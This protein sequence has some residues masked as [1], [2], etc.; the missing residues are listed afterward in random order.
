MKD[1]IK[2]NIILTAK[3]NARNVK[4]ISK[5]DFYNNK[6]SNENMYIMIKKDNSIETSLCTSSRKDIFMDIFEKKIVPILFLK[7]DIILHINFHDTCDEKGVL[8][9]GSLS[10]SKSVL[11]P[12]MF[13][14]QSYPNFNQIND[15]VPFLNKN[16]KIIFCGPS[17]GNLN[18]KLNQRVNTCL[19]SIKNDWAHDKTYFRLTD[20][21][22][23]SINELNQY[24]NDNNINIKNII[25]NHFHI[26]DQLN[27][28]Y[29]LNIDGNTWS[30]DRPIWVMKSNSLLF[31]Y[32]SEN[33]G[34]YSNFLKENTHYISVNTYNIEKKYNFFE[35]NN[36]QALEIIRNANNFVKDYCS[37]E[38]WIFYF[39]CLL[40]EISYQ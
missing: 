26:Y 18:L 13:Q 27:Y 24:S 6:L 17:T 21:V 12:D 11:I 10:K 34:W 38:S 5:F 25:S 23:M 32:T 35:N 9:F 28:K 8:T 30:W 3:K 2:D 33:I 4:N 36:N 1:E 29:I 39:K 31:N 22:Q 20:I 15:E 16:N 14:I 19:W 40:E 37:E 7:K